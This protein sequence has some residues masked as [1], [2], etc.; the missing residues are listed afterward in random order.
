MCPHALLTLSCHKNFLIFLLSLPLYYLPSQP[1]TVFLLLLFP[2]IIKLMEVPTCGCG[3]KSNQVKAISTKGQFAKGKVF[4]VDPNC[5]LVWST[6]KLDSSVQK[7]EKKR[8]VCLKQNS[9]L[10]TILPPYFF[11]F[12][13][14]ILCYLF[15]LSS[16]DILWKC[17]NVLSTF[18]SSIVFQECISAFL[19]WDFFISLYFKTPSLPPAQSLWI[20]SPSC[21]WSKWCLWLGSFPWCS[22]PAYTQA[23]HIAFSTASL[24]AACS[25]KVSC[26]L[27]S[28]LISITETFFAPT[29]TNGILSR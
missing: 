14:E 12:F 3:L 27:S 22:N 21:P 8:E 19:E 28:F 4:Q 25:V 10:K 6:D 13:S 1:P 7:W 23:L 11:L 9:I 18:I 24:N 29:C 16:W 20:L 2:C 5:E 26:W 15:C 17:Q